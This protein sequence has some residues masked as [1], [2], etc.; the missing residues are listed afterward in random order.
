MASIEVL[1]VEMK[2][3]ERRLKLVEDE[4]K[5]FSNKINEQDNA[6]DKI[7]VELKYIKDTLEKVVKNQDA[8]LGKPTTQ[9]ILEKEKS[10][11]W[12]KIIYTAIATIVGAGLGALLSLI[13]K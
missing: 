8:M 7:L 9:Q 11:K 6:T 12:D 5:I 10:A 1:E 2:E 3:I 13:I 4:C